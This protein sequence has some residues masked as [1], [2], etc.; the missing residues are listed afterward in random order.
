MLRIKRKIE[1]IFKILMILRVCE[2]LNSFLMLLNSHYAFSCVIAVTRYIKAQA[3]NNITKE[4]RLNAVTRT[5]ELQVSAIRV[6][7]QLR[8]SNLQL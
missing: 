2:I 1:N 4:E 8:N 6:Y 5:A 7:N 3:K